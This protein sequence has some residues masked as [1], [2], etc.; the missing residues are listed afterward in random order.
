MTTSHLDASND[1]SAPE[2][3][4]VWSLWSRSVDTTTIG[5]A[6]CLFA[7]GVV[8][9]FAASPPLAKSNGLEPFFYAWRH[10]LFGLPTFGVMFAVSFLSA[11]NIRRFGTI[12]ALL[13][14]IALILLPFYGVSH[15]KGA[16]RW[17]SMGGISVQPTEFLKPG[18]VIACAWT[19]S[20]LSEKDRQVAWMGALLSFFLIAVT[21]GMLVSQPD[22]GQAA[23]IVAVWGAMFF[24]SGAAP[25]LLLIVLALAAGVGVIGYNIEPH[26]AERIETYLDPSSSGSHQIQMAEQA[27]VEGGWFGRGLG[28]GV[29]KESLPDG[30]ADFIFAIAAEEYGFVLAVTILALFGALTLR[31][32]WR[33]APVKDPFIRVAGIGLAL[34]IGLQAFV[35]MAV[36]VQLLPNKGMTL[37][38]VSYGGSSMIATGIALGML[39]ALTRRVPRSLAKAV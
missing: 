16:I 34:L 19:L 9:A 39:L 12:L 1:H 11:R 37:P 25:W 36:T 17:F 5:L 20:A 23:L 15:A 33:L 6:L 30:H 22:Y 3:W 7:I 27:I 18:L 29:A 21:V 31:A 24:I 14:L 4:S 35:N 8:L 13:G 10:L 2:S 32:L 26:I 38:L 28:E